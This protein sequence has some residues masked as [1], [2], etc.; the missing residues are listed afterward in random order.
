MEPY[1][2]QPQSWPGGSGYK[3]AAFRKQPGAAEKVRGRRNLTG[4]RGSEEIEGGY[5]G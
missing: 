2:F 1:G 4:E 5:G 3:E